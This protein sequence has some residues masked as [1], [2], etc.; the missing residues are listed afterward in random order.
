MFHSHWEG[1]WGAVSSRGAV[2]NFAKYKWRNFIAPKGMTQKGSDRLLPLQQSCC[3]GGEARRF[4]ALI[5]V[6]FWVDG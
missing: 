2:A 5:E 3:V 6:F 4:R 1:D